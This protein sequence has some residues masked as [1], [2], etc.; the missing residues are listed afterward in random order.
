VAAIAR[1][2]RSELRVNDVLGAVPSWWAERASAAGLA[3]RWTDWRKALPAP[4]IELGTSEAGLQGATSVELA[5]AY[6][7]ALSPDVRLAEGRHYTPPVLAETLW[8]DLARMGAGDERVV[9]PACGAG[10]LLQPFVR[11]LVEAD[12]DQAGLLGSLERRVSGTDLDPAA[13]WLGNAILGAELLPLWAAL[14]AAE[15]RPLPRLLSVGDGL[16][17]QDDGPSLLVMNPPYGRIR[18]STEERERWSASLYGHA[19]RYGLFLHA[20]IERVRPG[21]IVA[22]VVPTSFLGGAYYQRLRRFVSDHAPLVHL[23]FVDAR[24]GV[25][26]G[27]VLQETCLAIFHKS[28]TARRLYCR[29]LAVNGVVSQTALPHVA[30]QRSERPW[31]LPRRRGDG[32]LVR[33]A[34]EL[35]LRLADYGWHPSTGPLVWNRHKR[36][37]GPVRGDDSVPILWAADIDDGRVLRSAAREAQRWIELRAR[38]EFML[39]REPAVL[40]QRTTAPEQLRRLVAASLDRETI[41]SWGGGVVVE[42]HVNILRCEEPQSPLTPELLVA[43]LRTATVDRL[44]R[45][46]TGTVAVSAYELAALPLP[47]TEVIRAWSRLPLAELGAAVAAEYCDAAS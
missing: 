23:T 27:D 41:A 43:L 29:R 5:E 37:I 26:S 39:L 31:L 34:G 7:A 38:D 21:G 32:P 11:K 47:P 46:I 19:N 8:R 12:A 2:A 40:V 14:P 3:G 28:A 22:A 44:Y 25:F 15:R 24:S 20:A 45:C 9:D 18:L 6:L 17:R 35:E 16:T 42:N 36:Q 30:R 10:A 1:A 4:P 13:I 33:R